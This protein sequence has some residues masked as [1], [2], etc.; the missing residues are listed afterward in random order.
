[1]CI[2]SQ[3]FMCS[4]IYMHASCISTLFSKKQKPAVKLMNGRATI[5]FG[6][7]LAQG[8][9]CCR[10]LECVTAAKDRLLLDKQD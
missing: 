10:H 9:R 6:E 4:Y 1:M 7:G 5:T 3:A 8:R 2:C